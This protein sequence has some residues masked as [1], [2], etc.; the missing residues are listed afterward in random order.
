[1][2]GASVSG[3]AVKRKGGGRRPLRK[4][5]RWADGPAGLERYEVRF[6]FFFFFFF[7]KLFLNQT[8]STQ[9]QTKTFQTFSEHFISLLDLT[10]A[11]KNDA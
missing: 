3:T 9:N 8:F 1:M 11:T 4:E 10:Q 6:S 5:G 2:G 7:F